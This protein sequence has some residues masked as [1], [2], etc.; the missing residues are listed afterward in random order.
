MRKKRGR[1]N[2]RSEKPRRELSVKKCLVE[3]ENENQENATRT[4]KG[5]DRKSGER[6][7]R[8]QVQIIKFDVSHLCL[9]VLRIKR[10]D[11]YG[12][13]NEWTL[14]KQACRNLDR[15]TDL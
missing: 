9:F 8:M 14:D 15:Q 11:M 13:A 4:C 3:V 2:G 10:T 5:K 7:T 12:N 1:G 6:L